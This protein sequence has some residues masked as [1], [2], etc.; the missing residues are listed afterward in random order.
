MHA[1][2]SP[3]APL[4]KRGGTPRKRML[5]NASGRNTPARLSPPFCKGGLGGDLPPCHT[6]PDLTNSTTSPQ[7]PQEHP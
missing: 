4:Y 7:P 1:F 2:E 6:P 3:L 5:A